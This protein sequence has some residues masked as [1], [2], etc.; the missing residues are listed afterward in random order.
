MAYTDIISLSD[1]KDY[2]GIDD[3]SR[4]T[5]ITRMIGAALRYIEEHTGHIM[6]DQSKTYR[7]SGR[8]SIRIYD[9]PINSVTKG[10][11]KAGDDVALTLDTNYTFQEYRTY[12]DYYGIDSDAESLV[13]NVGYVSASSI[14]A[15]LVEAGYMVLEHMFNQKE[16]G[17]S[18]IP[19]AAQQLMATH[20]RFTI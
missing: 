11:D 1:A 16:T 19:M 15:P 20:R 8:D 9:Y 4:D 14:P 7:L 10:L 3:T 17:N 6:E 12:T 18:Q 5:E 13:L 2:L